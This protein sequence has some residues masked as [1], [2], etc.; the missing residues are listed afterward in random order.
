MVLKIVTVFPNQ[1]WQ[2]G[3]QEGARGSVLSGSMLTSRGVY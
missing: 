2:R 3:Q 1:Q